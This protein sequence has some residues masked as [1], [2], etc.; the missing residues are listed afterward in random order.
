MANLDA[1]AA[2]SFASLQSS[3]IDNT[4]SQENA[5]VEE[6]ASS[7]LKSTTDGGGTAIVIKDTKDTS[8]ESGSTA[9]S[10][11]SSASVPPLKRFSS[12]SI[13]K[14]FLEKTSSASPSTSGGP[15]TAST[16][17]KASSAVARPTPQ[18]APTPSRLVTAKLTGAP[19][20]QS[21]TAGWSRPAA[22]TPSPIS[23]AAGPLPGVSQ[24]STSSQTTLS[25]SSQS[26][27]ATSG[28]TV[29]SGRLRSGSP[30][31]VHLNSVKSTDSK[32]SNNFPTAAE[33][34]TGRKVKSAQTQVA[35]EA[36]AA[37]KQA[38][39]Q[40]AD[41][42]RGVH[43]D[44]NAHH[45]DE[46]DEDADFLDDVID[47]GDGRQYK[48]GE[49]DEAAQATAAAASGVGGV[50]GPADGPVSKTERF[51][52]DFDRSWPRSQRAHSPIKSTIS[53]PP[54]ATPSNPASAHP[55]GSLRLTHSAFAEG[56]QSRVLFNERSNRL[57]PWSNR[58]SMH[59]SGLI[60]LRKE[61]HGDSSKPSSA[62]LAPTYASRVHLLHRDDS[63]RILDPT[64][65][66]SMR[67]I[68][69]PVRNPSQDRA[70]RQVSPSF[71]PIS[72]RTARDSSR[73]THR[74]ASDRRQSF[75]SQSGR[76]NS[77]DSDRAAGSDTHR[78]RSRERVSIISHMP[79]VAPT[80]PS[81][82]PET[83]VSSSI[84][85]HIESSPISPTKSASTGFADDPTAVTS[86]NGLLIDRDEIMK[87]AM[88]TAAER[89][90][91]R[92][93]EEEEERERQKERAR[94]KA[95]ELEAKMKAEA[96]TLAPVIPPKT[97]PEDDPMSR[98]EPQLHSSAIPNDPQSSAVP[99]VP[100][101]H[102]EN[103]NRLPGK[104]FPSQRGSFSRKL[105]SSETRPPP[106]EPR[107][108]PASIAESWRPKTIKPDAGQSPDISRSLVSDKIS[109][110]EPVVAL[111]LSQP[112][113]D[114]FSFNPDESIEVVEFNDLSKIMDDGTTLPS[115]SIPLAQ[116]ARVRSARPV[117]SDFFDL[118]DPAS[119]NAKPWRKLNDLVEAHPS[120]SELPDQAP[121][122]PGSESHALED[123]AQKDPVQPKRQIEQN[124]S[125]ET[126]SS[127]HPSPLPANLSSHLQH[128]TS[129]AVAPKSPRIPSVP[130]H[131]E[132]SM[133]T[134]D[135]VISRI[136]GAMTGFQSRDANH[137]PKS[138]HDLG[139]TAPP[140]TIVVS[141]ERSEIGPQP[142]S[143]P[144]KSIGITPPGSSIR[145][146]YVREVFD[147][148]MSELPRSPKPA[149]NNFA[150]KIPAQSKPI[151]PLT[152]QAANYFKI[153]QDRVRLDIVSFYPVEGIAKRDL[154]REAILFQRF[155][156]AKFKT[157][158]SLPTT[159]TN[160]A[161][162]DSNHAESPN[163]LPSFSASGRI[164]SHLAPPFKKFNNL[165]FTSGRGSE[166]DSWR[167]NAK[168]LP[169]L[170][171]QPIG[172]ATQDLV[173]EESSLTEKSPSTSS[174]QALTAE[175]P[176][177]TAATRQTA[178]KRTVQPKLPQGVPVGFSVRREVEASGGNGSRVVSFTVSSELDHSTETSGLEPP[179]RTELNPSPLE[180]ALAGSSNVEHYQIALE[181]P[182]AEPVGKPEKPITPPPSHPSALPW[183][184]SPLTFSVIESPAR[185]APDTDHL[186]ALWS[187]PTEKEALPSANSLRGIADDLTAIPFTLQDMKSEDGNTPPPPGPVAPPSR[188]DVA[189]AFQQ[190]PPSPRG[191]V[192]AHAFTLPSPAQTAMVLPVQPNLR[193]PLH[194][195]MRS[196]GPYP[197][198]I[199]NHSPSPTLLY[200]PHQ[201]AP[202]PVPQAVW[203]PPGATRP[204]T[205]IRGPAPA[206][207]YMTG[208][209]H[210]I[211]YQAAPT[212]FSAPTPPQQF[213][214]PSN[215]V[216]SMRSR[217]AVPMMSPGLGRNGQN[218]PS[219]GVPVYAG[220]PMYPVP[221]GR[222]PYDPS[223]YPPSNG[224]PQSESQIYNAVPATS[225]VRPW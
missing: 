123:N 21:S 47:F 179:S 195:Q 192:G 53:K 97:Q 68:H 210:V 141:S 163:T 43:L 151:S 46:E 150:V 148:T 55:N 183:G 143:R 175:I 106:I 174:T 100:D 224:L 27:V 217:G 218:H 94:K 15:S 9:P 88:L 14:K 135:D 86:A 165:S 59:N 2:D 95:L 211:Q 144:L 73:E 199:L 7:P 64:A 146:P 13:N 65:D 190:V 140:I 78:G 154:S 213:S 28:S 166:T 62:D 204:G 3:T 90:K 19:L 112:T 76:E 18:I 214:H 206:S 168:P 104:T 184:K 75:I 172:E 63:H 24:P 191:S 25:G 42:F 130:G 103:S 49:K 85:H 212:P 152:A 124:V 4:P 39:M 114:I 58:P 29:A 129:N 71:P 54:N 99:H 36:A 208:Q 70:E 180:G 33:A 167:K 186:K 221:A 133:S 108:S 80:A 159:K 40:T 216:N 96:E 67:V 222:V 161:N 72:Q 149:W 142:T 82:S 12:V 51:G 37:E 134:L 109:F 169:P 84:S 5:A 116:P 81:R 113:T 87:V 105:S 170:E 52:D 38:M 79:I 48:I 197:A 200:P 189:R 185:A 50:H 66:S 44:P 176:D 220:P 225:F 193:P 11:Q 209:P 22:S 6:E 157:R 188:I 10:I 203:A 173:A 205:Y 61:S 137:E 121:P 92:R 155:G 136:K 56:P 23:H 60:P 120:P 31:W 145:V 127:E 93:Q 128:P 118:P 69:P 139:V 160:R 45:W 26:R 194:H 153:P 111:P 126:I 30:A 35:A 74:S 83:H 138:P 17:S 219:Q 98:P 117:A 119:S 8:S 207:P 107:P 223:R 115:A 131:R 110:K 196:Y 147:V 32:V 102:A 16:N 57:E 164:S 198:P 215:A 156:K 132:G 41:T 158:V 1:G 201:M 122:T 177:P 91:R 178:S 182:S 34:A 89:A 171:E 162:L 181:K 125:D 20:S 202:S 77:R 187:Q 101:E